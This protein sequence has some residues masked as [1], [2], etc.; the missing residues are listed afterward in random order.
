MWLLNKLAEWPLMLFELVIRWL[1]SA[2]PPIRLEV[3]PDGIYQEEESRQGVRT[4]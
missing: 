2:A 1:P 3:S 4:N